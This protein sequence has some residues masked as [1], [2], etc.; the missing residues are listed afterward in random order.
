[1][2][3]T[4]RNST[5]TPLHHVWNGA[6]IL[7]LAALLSKVLSAGYRIPYHYI[8][9]DIGFYIYQQ[10]Y[11]FYG[12]AVLF[13]T[14]GFPVIISKL[15]AQEK[16]RGRNDAVSEIVKVSFYTLLLVH[17]LLFLLQYKGADQI[18]ALMGDHQLAGLIRIVSFSFLLAPF[19]AVFR[20]YYQGLNNMAPTA[21]SQVTEQ[22]VRVATILLFSYLLLAN[23]YGLYEAGAGAVF[24]SI[25]GGFAALMVLMMFSLKN[26]RKAQMRTKKEAQGRT[27]SIIHTL[28]VQG[29]L[30]CVSGMGLLFIQFI[31]SFTLYSQLVQEMDEESAKVLKGIYDRGLPFIQLG[32]VVGTAFSLALVPVISSAVSQKD[33]DLLTKKT[34]LAIRLSFVIGAGAVLGLTSIMPAAN[35][36]LYG[37]SAGTSMLKI[38][39]VTILFTTM[40]ATTAAI[41]QGMGHAS[42]SAWTVLIGMLVKWGLNI[43]LIPFWGTTGAAV[44]SV[45][46]FAVVAGGNI[47]YLYKKL[48]FAFMKKKTVYVTFKSGAIMTVA[49]LF[50]TKAL[51]FFGFADSGRNLETVWEALSATGIGGVIYLWL[52]L[53]GGLFTHQEVLNL[54]YG[55]KLS[56]WIKQ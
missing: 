15:I 8:A 46:S 44:S 12:L 18:A 33:Q 21:V 28:L 22:F 47:F 43:G 25:T 54:P 38:F 7:T 24:S 26:T 32:T 17:T 40:G 5:E 51:H 13:S 36:M 16:A 27:K 56:K 31:D 23:G 52:I 10:I 50:Y 53:R 42:A 3:K 20:G 30:A 4:G 45:L 37:N 1:L 29:T 14:Y 11:P 19:I 9:G 2:K 6:V 35:A 48:G 49:L 34:E 55:D 39:C 41:L